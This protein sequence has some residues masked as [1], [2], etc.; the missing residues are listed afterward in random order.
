MAGVVAPV[1]IEYFHASEYGNGVRV[2]EEFRRLIAA[3]GVTVNIRHIKDA[4]PDAMPPADLY[5]FS[6]PGRRG[7]PIKT[8]RRFL[9]AVTLP[10]G[11]KCAVLTTEMAPKPDRRTGQINEAELARWQRVLPIMN[12]LVQAKGFVNVA[13]G[14]IHVMAIKGPLEEGWQQ[15]VEAFASRIPIPP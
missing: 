11:T 8:M 3:R 14:Q 5:L 6:S 1:K 9:E 7:K 12:E 13:Q 15:K 10:P 2:A 4:R